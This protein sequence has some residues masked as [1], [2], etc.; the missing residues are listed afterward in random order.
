MSLGRTFDG[1]L[2][3]RLVLLTLTPSLVSGIFNKVKSWIAAAIPICGIALNTLSC[4]GASKIAIPELDIADASSTDYMNVIFANN[5]N[6]KWIY[7]NYV[8]LQVIEACPGY[9]RCVE[10]TV[11]GV[12][13]PVKDDLCDE[14][15]FTDALIE[16]AFLGSLV[17]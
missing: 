14:R 3:R 17:C 2:L 15:A 16:N 13:N 12:A 8:Y 10:I 9:A 1:S 11:W 6:E 7:T 4:A 5:A